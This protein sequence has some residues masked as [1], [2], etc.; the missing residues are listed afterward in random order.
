MRKHKNT[1]SF[2]ISNEMLDIV[3][4]ISQIKGLSIKDTIESLILDGVDYIKE[5]IKKRNQITKLGGVR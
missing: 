3:K 2:R 4:K 1:S 5:L